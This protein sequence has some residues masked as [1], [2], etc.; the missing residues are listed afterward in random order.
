MGVGC[1]I[2]VVV[3]LLILFFAIP[4]GLGPLLFSLGL[5][6]TLTLIVY[7]MGLDWPLY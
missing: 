3:W 6:L 2:G 1:L 4:A 5:V 7:H